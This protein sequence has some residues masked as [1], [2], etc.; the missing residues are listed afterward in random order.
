M[1]FFHGT[2]EEH[3]KLRATGPKFG[4]WREGEVDLQAAW[5]QKH[6]I[7]GR[8]AWQVEQ[9]S[10]VELLDKLARPVLKHVKNRQVVCDSEG[11]VE[12]RPLIS[13]IVRE[14][15]NDSSGDDPRVG[16]GQLEHIVTNAITVSN[17]EH[18]DA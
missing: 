18:S 2:A 14:G 13:P 12:I 11:Q 10:R 5:E 16:C 15:T 1:G 6:S 7:D 4:G 8:S 17:A 9:V 3:L